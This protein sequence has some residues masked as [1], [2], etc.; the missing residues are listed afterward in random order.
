VLGAAICIAA[1]AIAIEVGLAAVQRAL[2]PTP[3]RRVDSLALPDELMVPVP[4]PA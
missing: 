4:E 2:T 3:L 1:M